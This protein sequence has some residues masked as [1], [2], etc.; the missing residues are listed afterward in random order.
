MVIRM[1]GVGRT[2]DGVVPVHALRKVTLQIAQG[3]YVSVVGPSGAGKSTLLSIM[4][5]LDRPSCGEY[6]LGG[7]ATSAMSESQRAAWRSVHLGFVFQAFHLLDDRDVLGNV[8]LGMAYRSLTPAE[9]TTRAHGALVRVG[10]T[11]RALASPRTLSGGER[12]RVAIA[13]ALANQ[14]SVILADEPTGNLDTTTARRILADLES[15]N[16]DGTALVVVTHD[17]DTAARAR[18]RISVIDGVVTVGETNRR[19]IP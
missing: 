4:G 17:P 9:R 13:R 5:L 15:L 11:D 8:E 16:E 7:Q 12:Q 3:D 1:E 10:L 19:R 6:W 14:P 2:F 18:R